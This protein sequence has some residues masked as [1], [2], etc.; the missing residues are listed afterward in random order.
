MR[1]IE[2]HFL[3]YK[4]GRTGARMRGNVLSGAFRFGLSSMKRLGALRCPALHY[5][6]V[7]AFV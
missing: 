5:G 6:R 7:A 1:S 3:S 4:P 2:T